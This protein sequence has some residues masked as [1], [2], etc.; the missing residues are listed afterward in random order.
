MTWVAIV[1]AR[2]PRAT[3]KPDQHGD[4]LWR[5]AGPY[6]SPFKWAAE[7]WAK[8]ACRGLLADRCF[9]VVSLEEEQTVPPLTEG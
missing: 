9:S 7:M 5:I 2:S 3:W 1:Y 8:G 4:E 6:R